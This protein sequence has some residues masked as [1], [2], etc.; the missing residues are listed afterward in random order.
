MTNRI[1]LVENSNWKELNSSRQFHIESTLKRVVGAK[2][3]R[4]AS[5]T[6]FLS[7]KN[8][9][10]AVFA[11]PVFIPEQA[12]HFD[13]TLREIE[14]LLPSPNFFALI[15]LIMPSTSFHPTTLSDSTWIERLDR[16]YD[17]AI[18]VHFVI[19][20]DGATEIQEFH[21]VSGVSSLFR[22][23]DNL[24]ELKRIETTVSDL[25]RK[26]EKLERLQHST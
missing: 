19:L 15:F 21:V 14:K 20:H 4:S 3:F 11:I 26:V 2:V 18:P 5:P 17:Q 13:R 12:E 1:V 8:V 24:R 7:S 10:D 25:E 23:L 9:T 22:D 6:E 16:F